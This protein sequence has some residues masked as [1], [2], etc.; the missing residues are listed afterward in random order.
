MSWFNKLKE[1]L[2]K[3]SNK[4]SENITAV[5]SK[6]KLDQETLEEL[7]DVLIMA[8]LGAQTA[9]EVIQ[10]LSKSKFN[11]EVTPEEIKE[12][13]ANIIAEILTPVAKKISTKSYKPYTILV[14]G[15]NGNGKTTTIGKLAAKFNQQGEKVSIAA[16]DT[17]RAAAIEQLQIWAERS[18]SHFI[19]GQI[20]SDPASVAYKSLEEARDTASDILMIDTAGRLHNKSNLMDELKKINKVLNKQG[21][22]YPH[23]VLLVIDATTG[24]NALSQ[25]KYFNEAVKLTGLV[26]TKLDGSA[27]AGIVVAI[28]KKFG[29]PLYAIGVGEKIDDLNDFNPQEFARN[30]VGLA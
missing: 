2:K 1:G 13:L 20:K 28:A 16:C 15:V 25:V 17:F 18:A 22:E 8:D 19:T 9:S 27:K 30:L 6:K 11:K 26:I 23:E 21:E 14:V 4:L 12:E 3:T 10:Q 29:L 24:Q 7:E 5:V